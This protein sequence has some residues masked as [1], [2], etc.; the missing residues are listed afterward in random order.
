[1]RTPTKAST[2]TKEPASLNFL[3]HPVK[4][5]SLKN[6][7]GKNTNP[8]VSIHDSPQNILLYISLPIRE[9]NT[10]QKNQLLPQNMGTG[11]SQHEA[12]TNNQASLIYQGQ[13]QEGRGIQP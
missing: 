3:L 1:V 11:H 13:K 10:I 12:Y 4:D 8:I 6:K 2:C 7:Q 5:S 9:K